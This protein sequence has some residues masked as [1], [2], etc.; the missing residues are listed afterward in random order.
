MSSLPL[1]PPCCGIIVFYKDNN[2]IDKTILVS[3]HN[4]N[5]SF[6]KGKR[7]K[8]ETS[9]ETAWRE[10]T[11]ETGL[12]K[13]NVELVN[14]SFI[15][16]TSNRK[17]N[18]SVRYYVGKLVKPLETFTFDPE[19]LNKVEWLTINDAL[20]LDKFVDKRKDV[21]KHAYAKYMEIN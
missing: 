12:T 1:L 14:E 16:E 19:E 2:N 17:G 8:N 20:K 21:L 5:Y 7:H 6:P 18:L 11:E 10:L 15:D 4:G 13:D 9:L 3:T